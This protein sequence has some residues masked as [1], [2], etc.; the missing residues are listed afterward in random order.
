MPEN[1][2][3][4][5]ES[6]IKQSMEAVNGVSIDRFHDQTT[7]F[8][9]S[10]NISDF[11]AYKFPFEFYFECKT[12]HGNTFPLSNITDKQYF[13]MRDKAGIE[14]VYAGLLLW[15]IDKDVTL[16]VPIFEVSRIKAIGGKSIRYDYY[17]NG[18]EYL[19]RDFVEKNKNNEVN[20]N[21]YLVYQLTGKKKK[22]FFDYDME[23]FFK[24]F[25]VYEL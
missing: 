22:I 13:G 12:I 2:G 17:T 1:R 3:K 25:G 10:T 5:F 21:K 18:R 23:K 4:Q 11:V 9:G 8:A 15:F 7:G 20:M 14:G 19:N 24:H 6:L 16:F